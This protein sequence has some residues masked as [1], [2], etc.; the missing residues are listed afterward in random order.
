MSSILNQKQ[1]PQPNYNESRKKYTQENINNSRPATYYNRG[2][3]EYIINS[4]LLI[5]IVGMSI[6]IFFGN[7]ISKDGSYGRAN[8]TIY[9]Y[10]IVAFSILVVMFISFA[11]FDKIRKIE[12]KGMFD[13]IFGF[14]K[15][16]MTSSAPAL[17]TVIILLWIITLN[18]NFF[19]RINQGKV[20]KEYYQLS[21]GTSFLFLFQ[22][23][24]IFQYLKTYIAIKTKTSEDKDAAMTISRLAFATY[25]MC[26]INL[27]VVGMM[28]ILLN[29]FSTD[30]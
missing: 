6:K 24:A 21:A 15:T 12:N 7:N 19:T 9:G 2:G 29:F 22:V 4:M 10:G 23:L 3:Y 20:A 26:A 5:S 30:G 8:S 11:I 28:T 1:Q 14:I 16:F 25:F 27:V 18:S 13:S 17:L